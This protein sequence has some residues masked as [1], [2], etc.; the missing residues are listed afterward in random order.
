MKKVSFLVISL[1]TISLI[2]LPIAGSAKSD[3]GKKNGV[4]YQLRKILAEL[5]EISAAMNGADFG[6]VSCDNCA[7]IKGAAQ[8]N[9]IVVGE[10]SYV[11]SGEH[12]LVYLTGPGTFVAARIVRQED[13]PAVGLTEVALII[14]GRPV[15]QR[16]IEALKNW[17][18]TQ[19]NPFGVMLMSDPLEG[20]DTVTIGF[21]QPIYFEESLV[22][23][24]NVA[25]DD[26][27]QIL[28]TVIYGQ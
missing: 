3:R 27:V 26:V 22:L 1:L 7:N 9:G 11:A 2:F 15:V 18:M 17:G 25:D 12:E 24:A 4:P 14:D 6:G 28:G 23:K 19:N 16:N 8:M 13:D 20:I 21:S 10:G 5:E